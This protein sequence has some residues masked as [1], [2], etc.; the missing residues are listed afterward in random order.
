LADRFGFEF[1]STRPRLVGGVLVQVDAHRETVRDVCWT[2][3]FCGDS[4]QFLV[5]FT[6]RHAIV[7]LNLWC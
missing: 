1:V 2:L 3:S 6:D 4:I 5:A 7:A